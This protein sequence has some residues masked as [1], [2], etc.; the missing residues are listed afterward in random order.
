MSWLFLNKSN[1]ILFLMQVDMIHLLLERHEDIKFLEHSIAQSDKMYYY[2]LNRRMLYGDAFRYIS[3]FLPNKTTIIMNAD[4]YLGNGFQKL[5]INI[6][7][8]GTIYAL[9]RHET[10]K[11]IRKCEVK[12][13]CA[14]QAKYI[15][16]QDAF[17]LNLAKPL[18]SNVLDTLMVRQDIVGV[19]KFVIFILRVLGKFTVK[20]PCHTLLIFHNHCTKFRH[21]Q[22]RL[23]HG[24]RFNILYLANVPRWK[25]NAPFSGL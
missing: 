16:S 17:V 12:D 8:K 2:S 9:T 1:V 24:K 4:C 25:T 18:P 20:N 3:E 15:G 11:A 19:E 13:F 7:R 21:K 14:A 5:D 10:P 22:R 6:L 23:I